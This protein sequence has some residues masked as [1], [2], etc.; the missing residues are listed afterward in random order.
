M[1]NIKTGIIAVTK[2]DLAE[3]DWIELVTE[4]I[5]EFVKGTFLEGADIVPVSSKTGDSIEVLKEN[6]RDLAMKVEPKRSDGMFR[7]PIDRVFTLKGFGTVIT[8]TALSGKLSVDDKVE[9]QPAG[10][11]SM[12]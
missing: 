7:L 11:K 9:I 8:G 1:L 2:S 4:E 5:R 12:V 6:I 10:I 3:P